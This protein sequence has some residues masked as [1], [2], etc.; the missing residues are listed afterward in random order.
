MEPSSVG[1]DEVLRILRNLNYIFK[2]LQVLKQSH[3]VPNFNFQNIPL[4]MEGEMAWG[5]EVGKWDQAQGVRFVVFSNSLIPKSVWA[6]EL[7]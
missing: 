2:A 3:N 1:G 6:F 7:A 4:E 5:A